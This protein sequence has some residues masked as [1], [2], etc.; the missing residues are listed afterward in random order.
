MHSGLAR[1][2]RQAPAAVSRRRDGQAVLEREP[3]FCGNSRGHVGRR[4]KDS[5]APQDIPNIVQT[6]G[7]PDPRG[8]VGRPASSD[9]FG[10]AHALNLLCV[11][12]RS[13]VLARGPRFFRPDDRAREHQVGVAQL[14]APAISIRQRRYGRQ[15]LAEQ[16]SYNFPV[17]IRPS[18]HKDEVLPGC[19]GLG[20]RVPAFAGRLRVDARPKGQHADRRLRSSDG[21]LP[22]QIC[23]HEVRRHVR[24]GRRAHLL[25]GPR[26][27]FGNREDDLNVRMSVQHPLTF[28]D[29]LPVVRRVSSSG[30]Y[31]LR[32]GVLHIVRN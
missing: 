16:P 24:W 3:D 28:P 27:V 18:A 1:G 31:A 2:G 9:V 10:G 7:R 29:V 13:R 5:R 15:R 32:S 26:V 25:E 6:T 11:V 23:P 22:Q 21:L 12:L 8:R 17:R 19:P 30:S 14:V 20:V 4:R